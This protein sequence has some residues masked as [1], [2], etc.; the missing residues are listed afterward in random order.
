MTDKEKYEKVFDYFG[1]EN[2][3]RK[4]NEEMQELNDEILLYEKGMGDINKIIEE[5]GDLFNVLN[6]FI[7]NYD[8]DNEEIKNTMEYK[9]NRTITR[10]DSDYYGSRK[11]N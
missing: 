5:M 3:R 8:I 1:Y 2:Q 9:L 6:G 4:M 10:I 7:F 11:D